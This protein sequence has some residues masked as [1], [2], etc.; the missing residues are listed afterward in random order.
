MKVLICG[1][2]NVNPTALL[3][4]ICKYLPKGTVVICGGARG[5]DTCALNSA[6]R[7][8]LIVLEFPA[9]WALHGKAAGPIRNQQMLDQK[10]DLVIAIHEDESLGKGT[11]DMVTMARKAGVPVTIFIV[12]DMDP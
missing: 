5:V 3:D 6:N 1:S 7:L 12:E 4:E 10:P 9:D 11:L 8:N 2:R